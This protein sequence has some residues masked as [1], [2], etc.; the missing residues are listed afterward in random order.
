MAFKG[1]EMAN[2]I[3][4]K[5]IGIPSVSLGQAALMKLAGNNLTGATDG[6]QE[7]VTDEATRRK[8]NW[9]VTKQNQ[10]ADIMAGINKIDDYGSLLNA[11]SSDYQEQYG[12]QFDRTAVD[13]AIQSQLKTTEDNLLGSALLQASGENLSTSKRRAN[14]TTYFTK[15]NVPEG[16][17]S[18][19]TNR[20]ME[21]GKNKWGSIKEAA[22]QQNTQDIFNNTDDPITPLN[23]ESK[24]LDAEMRLGKGN[25]NGAAI[26]E[27][28]KVLGTEIMNQANTDIN[29]FMAQGGSYTEGRDKL[30]SIPGVTQDIIA[31]TLEKFDKVHGKT[32]EDK[33]RSRTKNEIAGFRYTGDFQRKIAPMQAVLTQQAEALKQYESSM[34][35]QQA[36]EADAYTAESGGAKANLLLDNRRLWADD[37]DPSDVRKWVNSMEEAKIMDTNVQNQMLLRLSRTPEIAQAGGLQGK[38]KIELYDAA[39]K[40]MITNYKGMLHATANHNSLKSHIASLMAQFEENKNV[41][42]SEYHL[43]SI[44]SRGILPTD[45]FYK[46]MKVETWKPTPYVEPKLDVGKAEKVAKDKVKENKASNERARLSKDMQKKAAIAEKNSSQEYKDSFFG[47]PNIF[48]ETDLLDITPKK[49]KRINLYEGIY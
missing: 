48:N 43:K 4:W 28:G 16:Q 33:E 46:P 30:K 41:Y 7:I 35:L 24:A 31:D 9:N 22:V 20:A 25:V 47:L 6:L 10:T 40:T 21:Q 45:S 18:N 29:T 15:H 26:R 19:F 42:A 27:Q 32:A 13:S 8:D 36:A 12:A 23:A 5:N 34:Q 14:L 39:L 37:P 11:H 1:A 17:I 49:E 2:P 38:N 3:T 44:Q